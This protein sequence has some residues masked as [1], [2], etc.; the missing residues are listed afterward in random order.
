NRF[1]WI[2]VVLVAIRFLFGPERP[3]WRSAMTWA[4]FLIPV[5]LCLMPGPAL[6]TAFFIDRD[7]SV[8][9]TRETAVAGWAWCEANGHFPAEPRAP[10]DA[11]FR[12]L[13]DGGLTAGLQVAS[14]RHP[15]LTPA[16][17]EMWCRAVVGYPCNRFHAPAPGEPPD[18]R[19]PM[20][21]EMC[22][23]QR[24]VSCAGTSVCRS[25]CPAAR[26]G[27]VI[28]RDFATACAPIGRRT[29]G[30]PDLDLICP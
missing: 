3:V 16:E 2:G 26:A 14:P 24:F 23:A 15:E 11:Y 25:L 8:T 21:P 30:P 29:D 18:K 13:G 27:Q 22:I 10:F 9:R 5:V 19:A 1:A 4:A 7:S 17:R 20:P 28:A 6:C 12:S